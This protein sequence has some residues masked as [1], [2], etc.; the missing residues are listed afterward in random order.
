MTQARRVMAITGGVSVPSARFRVRQLIPAMAR[1]GFDVR[2]WVPRVSMYPPRYR[3]A[4]PLWG[5]AAVLSRIPSVLGTWRGDLTFLQREML[6]TKC[7][8]EPLTSRPRVFDVDDALFIHKGGG[9][10]A[11]IAGLVDL[12][13]CGNDYLADRFS[14]WNANITVIPTAI[15]AARFAPTP[16]AA[17][18]GRPVVGWIGTAKN[19]RYLED[20]G[21]TLA[22]VLDDVPDATLR[23]VSDRA[24]RL[25][26]IPAARLEFRRWSESS[27]VGD[28]AD[29]SVGVMPLPDDEWT[30]GKCSF[31]MLQY[32]SCGL[33]VVVSPVGMNREVLAMGKPGLAASGPREWRDALVHLLRDEAGADAMGRDGRRI[34]EDH[35]SIDVV[36]PRLAAAWRGVLA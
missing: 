34:V 13:V 31:K 27:E 32:M 35:F 8:L 2:E 16:R 11:R 19:L 7:T 17:R 6:S 9:H 21:A 12:V 1:L 20:I 5:A 18:S 30:R 22:R 28:L 33:P 3:P 25:P 14:T 15:D 10:A 29:V 4:R 23:I 36:A 24:P 26:D